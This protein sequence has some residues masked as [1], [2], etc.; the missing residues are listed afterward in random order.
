[1]AN[2]RAGHVFIVAAPSGGGK[3]SLVKQV[4]DSMDDMTVSVSHTTRDKRA[5]EEEG[6]HYFFVDE[7]RFQDMVKQD[8]FI[9][10]ACVFDH[11]YGTSKAQIQEK[12]DAGLDVILDIDW[13]GAEQ[14]KALFPSAVGIFIVPPSLET[15]KARL[16]SRK[17]DNDQVI[18]DRMQ[19]ACDEMSHYHEFDYLIV[20]DDFDKAASELQ[21]IVVANRL[22]VARQIEKQRKLLSFLLS[23]Q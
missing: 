16:Q 23:S 12:L 6:K 2:H 13:Q 17:R 18:A 21:A 4:V 11:W 22:K 15:L 8:A 7:S 5:G 1:M 14:I 20:N 10:H 19:Q 9:E 3:T